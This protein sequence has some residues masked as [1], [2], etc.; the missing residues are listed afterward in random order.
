MRG[1]FGLLRNQSSIGSTGISNAAKHDLISYSAF[2]TSSSGGGSGRGRGQ[3]ASSRTQFEF[4][5]TQT[6]TP[7]SKDESD[8]SST[9][10]TLTPLGRGRG[11]SLPSSPFLSSFNTSVGPSPPRPQPGVGRGG[12]HGGQNQPPSTKSGTHQNSEPKRPIF[13]LKEDVVGEGSESDLLTPKPRKSLGESNLPESLVSVLKGFGRGHPARK[14]GPELVGK[15]ENR[16]RRPRQGG[17]DTGA[18]RGADAAEVREGSSSVSRSMLNSEEATK[19]AVIILSR[20]GGQDRMESGRGRGGRGRGRGRGVMGRGR[21]RGWREDRFRDAEDDLG[22]GLY[23]GDNADGEKLANKVGPEIMNE[24]TEAFEEMSYRVLPSPLEEE[25]LEALDTNL[26]IE[27]EPEY[28][29]EFDTNPDIDEK[30]PVPLREALEKMKPFLMAYEGIQSE[31][32]WQEIIKETMERVP[33]LKE[34]VDHYSGPDIV[35]A[36]QQQEELK[37]VAKT[38]PATAPDS[39]KH[40]TDRAVLS[41]Q[42]NPG[43]GFHKKCQFMDKLV[44]EVSRFYK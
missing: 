23:L 27:L 29:M 20:G 38:L 21:G 19:K 13:F 35:T 34:I 9:P 26:K 42:S 15:E 4:V 24:L 43:W 8:G 16:H 5:A 1:S 25:Y 28:L 11:K 36:K 33:L 6:S 39:V 10:S 41:L 32:E 3:G 22:P 14:P 2:S 30:S 17:L 12:G 7:D 31:E 37:R 44:S 40:F 18:R